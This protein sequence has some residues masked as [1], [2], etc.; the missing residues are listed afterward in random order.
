[1]VVLLADGST[2]KQ[3]RDQLESMVDFGLLVKVGR[4]TSRGY[5]LATAAQQQEYAVKYGL[6]PRGDISVSDYTELVYDA[7]ETSRAWT[8]L[9][10]MA[11]TPPKP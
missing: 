1:M 7:I 6:L 5:R 11:E 8:F 3:I 10:V 4:G 9:I 2:E